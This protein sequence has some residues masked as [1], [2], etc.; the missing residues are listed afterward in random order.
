MGVN[1]CIWVLWDPGYTG[2]QKSKAS[3]D[4]NGYLGHD[5]GSMAGEISP[6]TMF[7]DFNQKI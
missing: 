3:R 6:D 4:K 5:L 1:G 7:C 2:G